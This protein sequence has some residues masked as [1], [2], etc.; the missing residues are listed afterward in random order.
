MLK[1]FKKDD[2]L[3]NSVRT[4]PKTTFDIWNT[5]VFLN[6]KSQY[7][8]SFDGNLMHVSQ[9]FLSLLELNVDRRFSDH[10]YDPDLNLGVKAKIFPYVYKD[11]S[12]FS[13]VDMA[14]S[15]FNSDYS[16]GDIITASY[17]VSASMTRTYFS[18]S[19]TRSQVAALR[20]SFDYYKRISPHL[21][22]SSSLGDKSTQAINLLNIP[23]IFYGETIQKGSV[24]LSFFISGS[25]IG[26]AVDLYKNGL[27]YQ[28]SGS[29]SGSVAGHVL[30]NEGIISLTGSWNLS[31]TTYKFDTGAAHTPKWL[32]FAAGCNDGTPSSDI[33][34]SASFSVEFCGNN[35]V[36]TTLMFC[37]ADKGYFNFSNNP[38][39][40]N[41]QSSSFT[42]VS[43]SSGFQEE[44]RYI[45]NVVTSSF[46]D[47]SESFQ[48]IT[49]I[50]DV[51]IH[52]D[53]GNI[54]GIA[55]L[56]R[57]HRK[58]ENVDYTFKIKYDC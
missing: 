30:Y 53:F 39:F 49:Y 14:E 9:G 46:H 12:L 58:L 52:D 50:T 4:Y 57:P 32:D 34:P 22:Y 28:V 33:T 36:Q 20:N 23:K 3:T 21:A 54:L 47:F 44:D 45:Q 2:I 37:T 5:K 43:G 25:L 6:R 56:A 18:A 38:T 24:N 17:D 26:Q 40:Y 19:Q 13:T 41:R 35:P 48:R 15:T 10:T 8:G 11:N 7:S 31:A 55:K 27:L 29:G 51:Y 16:Y 1:K 42:I